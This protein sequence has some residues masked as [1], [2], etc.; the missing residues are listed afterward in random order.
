MRGSVA[1]PGRA[2]ALRR[3]VE[4]GSVP[5]LAGA[6]EAAATRRTG[7]VDLAR[8]IC[9]GVGRVIGVPASISATRAPSPGPLVLPAMSDGPYATITGH[10][11]VGSSLR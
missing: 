5:V 7:R 8:A 6:E 9:D 3:T 2:L 1:V 10:F 11:D 4:N